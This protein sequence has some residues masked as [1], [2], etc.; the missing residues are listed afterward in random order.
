MPKKQARFIAQ[1]YLERPYSKSS[2]TPEVVGTTRGFAA[3]VVISQMGQR[4]IRHWFESSI[5]PRSTN[6]QWQ[7]YRDVH[8]AAQ[9]PATWNYMCFVFR[10]SAWSV[11]PERPGH[12]SKLVP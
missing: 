2:A 11:W 7:R 5:D 1:G 8:I 9:V 12:D 4:L 3:A 6:G 10:V